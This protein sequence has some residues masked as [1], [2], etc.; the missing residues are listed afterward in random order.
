MSKNVLITA[1]AYH[2]LIN[3]LGFKPHQLLAKLP[4]S[5]ERI[6]SPKSNKF[7]HINTKTYRS[8]LTEYNEDDLLLRR[9]GY[10]KS[11]KSDRLVKVF[12][13][14]FNKL[15]INYELNELL[16]LPRQHENHYESLEERIQLIKSKQ[17]INNNT[18]IITPNMVDDLIKKRDIILYTK[19]MYHQTED[20]IS[21]D[22]IYR[23][24]CVFKN[25]HALYFYQLKEI[26]M[27]PQEWLYID[28]TLIDHQQI[29]NFDVYQTFIN[30]ECEEN[31]SD[32]TI[33]CID[34]LS[35][36]VLNPDTFHQYEKLSLSNKL[37]DIG[38]SH[39]WF[40][41]H[42]RHYQ[43]LDIKKQPMIHLPMDENCDEVKQFK[44]RAID[45]IRRW[46]LL[47]INHINKT[48]KL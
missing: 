39:L 48:N 32:T 2:M 44:S 17:C 35:Y 22:T 24:A 34:I 5:E 1:K 21:Y 16:K 10:I 14:S 46:R 13:K 6:K 25:G 26:R 42:I 38:Q 36:D 43:L 9:D 8:L 40:L 12:S 27:E 23:A 33:E 18:V 11:P 31:L 28:Y 19:S 47:L 4:K 7:I 20:D 29:N 45:D 30:N 37:F 41:S 3:D 15:L